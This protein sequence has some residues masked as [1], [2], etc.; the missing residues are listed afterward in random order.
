MPKRTFYKIDKEKQ[1][2]IIRAAVLEFS[3]VSFNEVKISNIINNAGIPRTSFY[4]YFVDKRD[5][6][7][8]VL[9]LIKDEKTKFMSNIINDE[10][11]NFFEKLKTLIVAGYKFAASNPEYDMIGRKMYNNLE[12]IKDI[13]SAE[14]ADGS[15]I[16]KVLLNNAI[17]NGEFSK[18]IDI[19]FVAKSI[20][21]L[22]SHFMIENYKTAENVDLSQSIEDLSN[23]LIGFIKYGLRS[24]KK[25]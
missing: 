18:D 1:E 16:Y 13:F 19:E 8:Y 2:C 3:K 17:K 6:Y 23:K 22:V 4:D 5:I 7:K 12:I 10:K 14:T 24:S 15:I 25:E 11:G 20:E 9:V 21:V